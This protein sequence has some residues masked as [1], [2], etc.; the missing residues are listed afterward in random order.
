MIHIYIHSH[1][2]IHLSVVIDIRWLL[3]WTAFAWLSGLYSVSFAKSCNENISAVSQS[4]GKIA[5]DKKFCG[6][7]WN[8]VLV[9]W[10]QIKWNH[11]TIVAGDD[12][13]KMWDFHVLYNDWCCSDWCCIILSDIC[14]QFQVHFFENKALGNAKKPNI[15]T[16]VQFRTLLLWNTKYLLYLNFFIFWAL[17]FVKKCDQIYTKIVPILVLNLIPFVQSLYFHKFKIQ[18]NNE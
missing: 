11:W 16:L 8:V 3:N 1:I 17:G 6:H 14:L 12:P 2:Q 4:L 5:S 10:R 15:F 7:L 9:Q 13:D 18:T